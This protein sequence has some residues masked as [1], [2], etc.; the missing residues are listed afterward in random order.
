MTSRTS[1]EVTRA[2]AP[3]MLGVLLLAACVGAERRAVVD[4]APL[5]AVDVTASVAAG[6]GTTP[7]QEDDGGAVPAGTRYATRYTVV[8][9]MPRFFAF[10]DSAGG[11]ALDGEAGAARFRE[12]VVQP[13]SAFYAR[14]G[15]PTPERV[16]RFLQAVPRDVAAMRALSGRLHAELPRYQRAFVDSFP[17]FTYDGRVYF[18]PSLYVRDGGVMTVDGGPVLMFGVDMIARLNGPDARLSALFHHELFHLHHGAQ[19]RQARA[20]HAAATPEGGLWSRVWGEGLA[21]YV[22]ARL[23]PDAT[24]LDVLLQDSTLAREGPAREAELAAL[25]LEQ[26]EDSTAEAQARW[27]QAFR[28]DLGQPARAGYYLGYRVAQRLGE[29]R[30]VQALAMLEGEELRGAVWQALAEL[31][32]EHARGH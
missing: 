29:R 27:F 22:S 1:R 28:T 13:E 9:L 18:Y 20:A 23:D 12:I 15:A 17:D 30:S 14:A 5:P 25:L 6:T 24:L 7:V 11:A 31:A 2:L 32:E 21:T 16:E 26:F 4:P 19:R 3:G 8:D 10:W